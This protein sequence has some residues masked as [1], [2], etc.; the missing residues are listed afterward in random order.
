MTGGAP[1]KPTLED[2]RAFYAYLLSLLSTEICNDGYA[3]TAA[4]P[5]GERWMNLAA[6]LRHVRDRIAIYLEEVDR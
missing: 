4:V 5:D 2:V 1:M 3:K 6:K